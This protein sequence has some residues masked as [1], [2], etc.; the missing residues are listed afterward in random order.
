MLRDCRE[1]R[2]HLILANNA[3]FPYFNQ[4]FMINNSEIDL[5]FAT[6]LE[7]VRWKPKWLSHKVLVPL[8]PSWQKSRLVHIM[9]VATV[10]FACG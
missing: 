1:I 8:I 9:A 10:K 5:S 6:Y 4:H 2:K 3:V 7:E